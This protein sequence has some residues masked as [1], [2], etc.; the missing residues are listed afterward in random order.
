[1]PFHYMNVLKVVGEFGSWQ[2]VRVA[3]LWVFMIVGGTHLGSRLYM[4][5]LPTKGKI[6]L[7]GIFSSVFKEVQDSQK[8]PRNV[9]I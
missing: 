1:M 6:I 4:S 9:I 2:A 7:F 3:I 5:Q 8:F